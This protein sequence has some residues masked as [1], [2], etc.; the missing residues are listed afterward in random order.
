MAE[1]EHPVIPDIPA[2]LAEAP[3]FTRTKTV[4]PERVEMGLA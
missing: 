1:E 2:H 3:I 4:R